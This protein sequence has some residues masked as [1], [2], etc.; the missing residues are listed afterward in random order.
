MAQELTYDTEVDLG[1]TEEIKLNIE[2]SYDLDST[3]EV[4]IG[5]FYA[6]Y[7]EEDEQ[8][9]REYEKVPYWLHKKLKSGVE[10]YKYD[11]LN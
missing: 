6:Y 8:G 9:H 11:M 10:D 3:G 1:A 7:Y 5:D 4:I 2:V